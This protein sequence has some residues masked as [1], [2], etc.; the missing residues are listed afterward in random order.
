MQIFNISII[1][2]ALL[3]ALLSLF[4]DFTF[5][6]KNIFE[7]WL[8]FWADRW[9][10]KHKPIVLKFV[11]GKTDEDIVIATEGK[12]ETVREYKHERVDW[13]W[14]KPL[15]GCVVCMNVWISF[16]LCAIWLVFG[17]LAWW[18]VLPVVLLSNFVVRFFQEKIV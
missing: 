11:E 3:S 1:E 5:R 9:L 8:D 15:G 12:D 4:L 18:G 16:V 2:V 7:K 10:E 17:C 6:A 13:F 14:F